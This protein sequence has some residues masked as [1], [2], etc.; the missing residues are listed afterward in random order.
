MLN[1]GAEIY[2]IRSSQDGLILEDSEIYDDIF[3]DFISVGKYFLLAIGSLVLGMAISEL[4]NR[5]VLKKIGFDPDEIASM[6]KRAMEK[7]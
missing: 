4:A 6:Y 2:K 5:E 3:A 1:E 7:K